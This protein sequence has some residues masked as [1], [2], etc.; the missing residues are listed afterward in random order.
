LLDVTFDEVKT[1]LNRLFKKN[2]RLKNRLAQLVDLRSQLGQKLD[3]SHSE[4][5]RTDLTLRL[6]H[7]ESQIARRD[8]SY[9][10]NIA[11]IEAVDGVLHKR[12]HPDKKSYNP[13]TRSL[14]RQLAIR[15]DGRE[16]PK[17][18]E[19]SKAPETEPEFLSGGR[20]VAVSAAMCLVVAFIGWTL[21]SAPPW[22]PSQQY[23]LTN[24]QSFAG[25][26]VTEE[27]GI[28]TIIRQTDRSVIF[29]PESRIEA[30]HLCRVRNEKALSASFVGDLLPKSEK[31]DYP[32]CH[33]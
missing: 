12:L 18:Q 32:Q 7:L 20:L 28:L 15:Y 21:V 11:R 4:E 22:M 6:K 3:E 16:S 17:A 27:N 5:E 31:P 24:G 29:L 26:E 25:Y 14:Y 23:T 1:E 2:R 8:K 10:Q 9:H 13:V 30:T 19:P 33:G